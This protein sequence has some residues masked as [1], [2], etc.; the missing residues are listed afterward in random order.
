[1]E[2]ELLGNTNI[3]A[4]ISRPELFKIYIDI[5]RQ[6]LRDAQ[7]KGQSFQGLGEV[8]MGE[9]DEVLTDILNSPISDAELEAQLGD[10]INSDLESI[11]LGAFWNKKSTRVAKKA[12]RVEKRE[13]RGGSRLKV[14]LKTVGKVAKTVVQKAA[15]AVHKIVTLPARGVITAALAAFKGPVARAFVYSY[16]P[17]DSPYL[18]TNP[19][20]KRKR[21]L[22]VKFL[23]RVTKAAA[24]QEGYLK[25]HIH[26]AIEK[27]YGM[28]PEEVIKQVS[29]G[30]MKL[31][32]LGF[33]P[34]SSGAAIAAALVA[35]APVIPVVVGIFNPKKDVPAGTDWPNAPT[36]N[37]NVTNTPSGD[38]G[39][40]NK[41]K[42]DNK[43]MYW[44]AGGVAVLAV[45]G[46]GIALVTKSN[47]ARLNRG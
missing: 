2:L 29:S 4:P 23:D 21:E 44:I 42:S 15:K 27:E 5:D 38:E 40:N 34:A 10:F 47:S 17:A 37:T 12:V 45:T 18:K 39:S 3:N 8:G 43:T 46:I 26:N 33:E 1:M 13:E 14:A 41:E 7:A 36:A 25:K 11:D 6:L 19:E 9:L 28:S 24:F 22:A 35:L 20:V 30:Q 31:Q 16:I 32:G